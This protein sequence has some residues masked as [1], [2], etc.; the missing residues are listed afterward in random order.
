MFLSFF[1]YGDMVPVTVAGKVLG[2]LC[3]LMGILMLA[4]PTTMMQKGASEGKKVGMYSNLP[5]TFT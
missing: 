5:K 4:L 2:S 3:C 1:S